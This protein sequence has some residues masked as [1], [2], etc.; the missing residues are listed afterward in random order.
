MLKKIQDFISSIFKPAK[1]GIISVD[2][3]VETDNLSQINVKKDILKEMESLIDNRNKL[4]D[5]SVVK[6]VESLS[7]D[8]NKLLD[9]DVVKKVE[10]L[11]DDTN[12]LLD[13]N[14]VEKVEYLSEDTNKLLD[15]DVV[16]KVESLSEDTN[17]LLD[18]SLVE[19]PAQESG[20]ITNIILAV[21]DT[22]D[23]YD[24]DDEDL[25]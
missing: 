3:A 18:Q 12:K 9:K 10:S 23:P 6:K 17:K 22:P 21:F 2:L 1:Q 4:L 11:S 24:S 8:T 25:S 16:E 19:I 15:K 14:V 7:D 13:K 5:R 20:P